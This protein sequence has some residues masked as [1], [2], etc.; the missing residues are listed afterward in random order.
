[1]RIH[2]HTDWTFENTLTQ[3]VLGYGFLF[4]LGFRSWRVQR[5]VQAVVLVGCWA[6][7]ALYPLPVPGFDYAKAGVP[8]D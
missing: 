5:I 6:L 3:I 8:S 4:A 1:L 7:F 2:H